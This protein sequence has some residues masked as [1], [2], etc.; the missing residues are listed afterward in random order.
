MFG[1]AGEKIGGA[2]TMFRRDVL[3]TGYVDYIE[4]KLKDPPAAANQQLDEI[5][6]RWAAASAKRP[7][8][9]SDDEFIFREQL[10]DRERGRLPFPEDDMQTVDSATEKS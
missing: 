5:L 6:G 2:V 10:F 3:N 7:K 4:H 1:S 9:M 8:D